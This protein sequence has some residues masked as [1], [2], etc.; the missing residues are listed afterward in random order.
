MK[1]GA[2]PHRRAGQEA[3]QKG[4]LLLLREDFCGAP[5]GLKHE[6]EET[7]AL[8]APVALVDKGLSRHGVALT[9]RNCQEQ[10]VKVKSEVPVRRG[11]GQL[12]CSDLEFPP[13]LVP[14][15]KDECVLEATGLALL[16][17][18]QREDPARLFLPARIKERPGSLP[19]V[20]TPPLL[21]TPGNL[22]GRGHE[23]ADL[24]HKGLHVAP[25]EPVPLQG[26]GQL[27]SIGQ[28]SAVVLPMAHGLLQRGNEG[29]VRRT[30]RRQVDGISTAQRIGG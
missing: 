16:L 7:M 4:Q 22:F 9:G 24:L 19:A 14:G 6:G 15:N 2:V 26:Q 25:L 28:L 30:P 18:H 23:T 10:A 27:H 12:F 3:V 21:L 17:L 13:I 20:I 29:S 1:S 5:K 11:D 8:A